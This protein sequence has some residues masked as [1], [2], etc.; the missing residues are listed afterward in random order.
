MEAT[1]VRRSGGGNRRSPSQQYSPRRGF[2]LIEVLVVVTILV[3]LIAILLPSFRSARMQ[4]RIVR[5]HADLRQITMALDAYAMDN[6]DRLPPTRSACGSSVNNQLPVELANQRYF[7]RDPSRIPQAH[8]Q[9][10][11][12]P[13]QTYKYVAPG[14]IYYN[15]ALFDAPREKFRLRSKVWVPIDFPN[16]RNR[17]GTWYHDFLDEPPS[18]VQYAVW[19]MGPDPKAAKLPRI[20]GTDQIDEFRLPLPRTYWLTHAGDVGVI[21]HFRSR[22]GI[23]YQSP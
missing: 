12:N 9:D 22:Q 21:T 2:T 17:E 8:F 6:R 11:L 18:P 19:S 14:P 3:L 20:E 16:C 7:P 1:A 10:F 13:T 15:G 4:S 23:V 5:V